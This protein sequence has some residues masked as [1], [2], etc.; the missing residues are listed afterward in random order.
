M[1]LPIIF[2]KDNKTNLKRQIL[3]EKK[4]TPTERLILMD[5]CDYID[6]GYHKEKINY[7]YCSYIH[8]SEELGISKKTVI[9]SIKKLEYLKYI[10]IEK[11]KNST[12]KYF[13]LSNNF[14]KNKNFEDDT[15]SE[16]ITPPKNIEQ[17]NIKDEFI[18]KEGSEKF[19]LGVVKNLHPIYKNIRIKNSRI[20]KFKKK[21]EKNLINNK[22]FISFTD[23]YNKF[24]KGAFMKDPDDMTLEE[25]REEVLKMFENVQTEEEILKK[26]K[27]MEEQKKKFMKE[28]EEKENNEFYY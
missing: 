13:L 8:L 1:I 28:C 15:S 17:N 5:I 24:K 18:P 2:N 3:K 21:K 20:K 9:N 19:T 12:N 7:A 25:K 23:E 26:R 14:T 10:K 11:T 27:K 22:N 6:I 16:K 4:L